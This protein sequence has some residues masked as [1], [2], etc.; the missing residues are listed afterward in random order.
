MEKFF[1]FFPLRQLLPSLLLYPGCFR[2]E[3]LQLMACCGDAQWVC[4]D[5]LA[6][7]C[8]LPPEPTVSG[9]TATPLRAS[10]Y[11]SESTFWSTAHSCV[12]ASAVP[13]SDQL[14]GCWTVPLLAMV[15]AQ[16]SQNQASEVGQ[17]TSQNS[18]QDPLPTIIL[19]IPCGSQVHEG[20][21]VFQN[22]T[23]KPSPPPPQT[24]P[25]KRIKPKLFH[26]S[27]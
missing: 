20:N 1:S 4:K 12:G 13:S 16:S 27:H 19:N 21:F 11:N 22:E 14:C 3:S 17:K 6:I 15:E 8:L 24:K 7:P 5:W 18:Y 25:N 23:K 10:Y 26:T 9:Y 2:L